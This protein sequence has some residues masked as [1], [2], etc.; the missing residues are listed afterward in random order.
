MPDARAYSSQARGFTGPLNMTSSGEK[1]HSRAR[2]NSSPETTS[3]MQ[4]SVRA[5][6]RIHGSG[7]VFTEYATRASGLHASLRA[8]SKS[9]KFARS[10]GSSKT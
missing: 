9:A 6:S 10:S 5:T 1:P 4:P 7:F 3:A 8:R 2:A